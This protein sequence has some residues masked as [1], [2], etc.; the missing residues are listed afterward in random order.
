MKSDDLTSRDP[1]KRSLSPSVLSPEPTRPR[2]PKRLRRTK[3]IPEYDAPIH[4]ASLEKSNPMSRK[5][6]KKA[7]KRARRAN[8]EAADAGG[9]GMEVD[10]MGDGGLEFTFMA[11]TEGVSF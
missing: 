3:Y 7:A 8:R 5:V 1:R 2:A 11:T 10:G 9:R 4:A 6:L